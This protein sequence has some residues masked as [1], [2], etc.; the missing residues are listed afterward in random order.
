[1]A[2]DLEKMSNQLDEALKSETK[3]SIDEFF[4]RERKFQR[5]TFSFHSDWDSFILWKPMNW[6][7][8]RFINLYIEHNCYSSWLELDFSLLGLNFDFNIWR[9]PNA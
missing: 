4:A 2:L 1:M 3:E 7:N 9:K 8:F 5:F 6:R